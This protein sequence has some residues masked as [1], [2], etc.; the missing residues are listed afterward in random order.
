MSCL[1]LTHTYTEYK[2]STQLTL[3]SKSMCVSAIQG[4]YKANRLFIVYTVHTR[5]YR[6]VQ[7]GPYRSDQVILD[8][9]RQFTS[10]SMKLGKQSQHAL[11]LHY[12]AQ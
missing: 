11:I 7:T 6:L 3:E 2:D 4:Q 12:R 1:L 10:S 9:T 5:D 8:H